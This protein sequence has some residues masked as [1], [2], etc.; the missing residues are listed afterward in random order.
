LWTSDSFFQSLPALHNGATTLVIAHRGA[1]AYAPENTL[2]AFE[3][4]VRQGADAI[5]LDAMLCAGEDIVVIHDSTLERTTGQSGR[6]AGLTLA[7]LKSLDAGAWFDPRFSGT[8]IPTLD[9]VLESV[10]RE[11]LTNIE[12]KNYS[13]PFDNLAEK[14]ALCVSRH[15][16]KDRVLFSSFNPLNFRAL[17]RHMPDAPVG[18][19]TEKGFA[20][21]WLEGAVRWAFPFDTLHPHFT[22]ASPQYIKRAHQART[23]VLAYT[24]NQMQA[25]QALFRA[26]I[27]GI[28]TDDPPLAL[29]AR[30]Q[31][32]FGDSRP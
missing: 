15:N 17:K 30:G 29:K 18:F 31:D 28:I 8:R 11:L 3:L 14:I 1:S 24:V 21:P 16:L 7:D 5:E 27:D 26:G 20:R 25:M 9:E 32:P 23:P 12:I 4:A 6:V 19:L 2:P 10:G 22:D 13:T